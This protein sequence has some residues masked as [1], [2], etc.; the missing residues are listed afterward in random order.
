MAE[1]W[2]G[3]NGGKGSRARPF[4]VDQK[5]FDNNW[6]L[7]FGKKKKETLPEYELNKSTGEVQTV[8]NT[9]TDKNEYQ[10]VLS[11]E[12]CVDEALEEYKRQAQE[13]WSDSCTTPRK[14]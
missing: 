14:K 3:G 7:A 10:D 6:E 8:D 5:T 9:G 12:D 4:S 2:N 1:H 11:T 13:M